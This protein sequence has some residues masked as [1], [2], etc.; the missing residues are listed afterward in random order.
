VICFK[1]YKYCTLTGVK[2]DDMRGI[3]LLVVAVLVVLTVIPGCQGASAEEPDPRDQRIEDLE[4]D[5]LD[6]QTTA[7]QNIADAVATA[8][9]ETETR[10]REEF[11][12]ALSEKD[13][14]V[15]DLQADVDWLIEA[16]EDLA[17]SNALAQV[18]VEGS[19]KYATGKIFHQ[20][21]FD[22]L[23]QFYPGLWSTGCFP[24]GGYAEVTSIDNLQR[25]LEADNISETARYREITKEDNFNL[26]D[27]A[28]YAFKVRWV[29]AGLPPCCLA[30]LKCDRGE[31]EHWRNLFI[32]L[33]EGEVVFYEVVPTRDTIT[34]IEEPFPEEE[35][36]NIFLDINKDFF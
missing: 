18:F 19:S 15:V 22:A 20:D 26:S 7:D 11:A 2:E 28:A 4:G 5:L 32:A 14:Q 34:R 6:C 8:K 16:N 10:L 1:Q 24:K 27:Q 33:E 31:G 23:H 35:E 3:Q 21:I 9:A 30:L 36:S 25:F 29:L 12:Q 13:D 17:K